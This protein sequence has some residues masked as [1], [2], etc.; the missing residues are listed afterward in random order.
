MRGVRLAATLSIIVCMSLSEMAFVHA[1]EAVVRLYAA[2]SLRPALTEVIAAFE[3]T[4]GVKVEP[5]F[6]A[7]GLLRQRL[8]GG[9]RGDLFCIGRHGAAARARR[10]GQSGASRTVRAQSAMRSRPPEFGCH[11]QNPPCRDA[12]SRGPARDFDTQGRPRWRLCLGGF[13]QGRG[14]AAGQSRTS[15]SQSAQAYGEPGHAAAVRGP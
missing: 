8:A 5:T 3:K 6:G 11:L 2:G 15:R 14:G 7:S 9:E 4:R 10:R 1:D 12:R 13:S